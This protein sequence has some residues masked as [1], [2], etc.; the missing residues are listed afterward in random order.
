MVEVTEKI[1]V[2]MR[3]NFEKCTG[4][5]PFCIRVNSQDLGISLVKSL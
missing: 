2:K 5:Q 4:Y 3:K 1:S